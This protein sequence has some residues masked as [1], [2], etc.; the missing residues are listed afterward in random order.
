MIALAQYS[1]NAVGPF[2]GTDLDPRGD[3]MRPLVNGWIA[4]IESADRAR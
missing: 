2:V 3:H 4:K 1:Q